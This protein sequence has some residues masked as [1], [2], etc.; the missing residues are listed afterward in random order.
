M[1][2]FGK[3]E[4]KKF[5]ESTSLVTPEGLTEGSI[6]WASIARTAVEHQAASWF[7]E[8]KPCQTRE[9]L[10]AGAIDADET[11]SNFFKT[12]AAFLDGEDSPRMIPDLEISTADLGEE[13][14]LT[15]S[16]LGRAI[17]ATLKNAGVTWEYNTFMAVSHLESVE[18]PNSRTT[19]V[20]QWGTYFGMPIEQM[21]RVFRNSKGEETCLWSSNMLAATRPFE[22]L[23]TREVRASDTGELLVAGISQESIAKGALTFGQ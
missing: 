1:G 5:G 22:H 9:A 17:V 4:P 21:F 19:G 11:V 16:A 14:D 2:L 20:A 13:V 8:Y 10:P 23:T 6:S 3:R 15:E 18:L 12:F 7:E